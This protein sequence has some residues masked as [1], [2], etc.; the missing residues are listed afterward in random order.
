M[1]LHRVLVVAIAAALPLMAAQ[2]QESSTA[3]AAATDLDGVVVTANRVEQPLVETPMAVTALDA[4]TLD[5]LR[6]ERF[7]DYLTQVPGMSSISPRPGNA[8]LTLRG[9]GVGLQGNSTVSLYVDD[10]PFGSSSIFA[11]AGNLTADFDPYDMARI[12]VLRGPQ[13]TL[14]GANSLGGLLKFVTTPPALGTFESQAQGQYGT[15]SGGGDGWSLRGLVNAPIGETAA[16]RANVFKRRD[17]GYIDDVGLGRKDING[18]D[19]AGGR[20]SLLWQPAD[21]L[22]VRLTSMAQDLDSLGAP[23]VELVD[24]AP[25]AGQPGVRPDLRPAYGGLTQRRWLDENF[26]VRMRQHNLSVQYDFDRVSLLSSSSYGT[27]HN[28]FRSDATVQWRG[29]LGGALGTPFEG[30]AYAEEFGMEQKKFT[31]EV[32]AWTTDERTLGWQ[33]GLYYSNEETGNRQKLAAYDAAERTP[34]DLVG[35]IGDELFVATLPASYDEI[36]AYGTLTWRISPR[37]DVAVGARYS[38]NEQEFTQ[39]T[40][41]ALLSGVSGKGSEDATWTYLVNPRWRVRDGLMFY[42]RFATGYRPG[43]PNFV[44]PPELAGVIPPAFEPDKLT[45]YE[46][47]M[48]GEWLDRRVG[49]ELAAYYVDWSDVQLSVSFDGFGFQG[50][51]GRSRSQGLE[52]ALNL[53]PFDGLNLGLTASYTDAH[54]TDEVLG[55]DGQPVARFAKGDRL[56]YVPRVGAALNADYEGDLT[57]TLGWFVGASFRHVGE[58]ATDFTGNGAGQTLSGYNQMDLRA[59]LDSSRWN[60]SLWV[61]N[62]ANADD[63]VTLGVN[64]ALEDGRTLYGGSVLQPRT[65]GITFTGYFH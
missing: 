51:G 11:R 29:L 47:G 37:F 52:A 34:A 32:R 18:S 43:G 54:L 50:N 15:V 10:S 19:V 45:S 25:G 38:R 58:R 35:L 21:A 28:R 6:I 4:R 5:R 31:Q 2:A 44:P 39:D 56:P 36:A 1:S 40:R 42:G 8:Q 63:L 41:G 61:K 53:R 16:L 65:V 64:G 9:V 7:D 13:G 14:Y 17:P 62:A 33:A 3:E 12:E 59:G 26:D 55:P 49:L 20:A 48:K 30:F 60:L 57:G 46:L 24:A 27:Q 22:R 23:V